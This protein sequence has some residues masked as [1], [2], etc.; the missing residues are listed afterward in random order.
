MLGRQSARR[1]PSLIYWAWTEDLTVDTPVEP[2]QLLVDHERGTGAR[3]TN[4]S[5]EASKQLGI[6]IRERRLGRV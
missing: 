2:D 4:L 1:S 6:A 3:S 5:L